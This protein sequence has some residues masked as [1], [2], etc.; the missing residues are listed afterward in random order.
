MILLLTTLAKV[1]CAFRSMN[2]VFILLERLD[3]Y[4]PNL[5]NLIN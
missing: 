3:P 4:T 1:W 2:I 5:F